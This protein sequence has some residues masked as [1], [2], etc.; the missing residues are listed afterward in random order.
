MSAVK[1][2]IT[3]PYSLI[4]KPMLIQE[5]IPVQTENTLTIWP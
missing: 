3:W 2:I 1:N 4:V 5:A